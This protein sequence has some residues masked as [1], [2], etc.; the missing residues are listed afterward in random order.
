MPFDNYGIHI[1]DEASGYQY[2]DAIMD[3]INDE[4][5][6]KVIDSLSA[7]NCTILTDNGEAD[8]DHFYLTIGTGSSGGYF[9]FNFVK[10]ITK[11][12]ISVKPYY[13]SGYSVDT[14]ATV[15]L[16][17]D[18]HEIPNDGTKQPQ[19]SQ[20]YEKEFATAKHSVRLHN[21]GEKQRF[22]LE[23]VEVTFE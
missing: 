4:V 11:I 12:K 18:K 2:R 15:Y 6:A 17:N 10:K 1:S 21:D 3:S 9:Q 19:A 16:D 20:T 7:S 13:K 14:G 8:K 23:S 22:F 5:G